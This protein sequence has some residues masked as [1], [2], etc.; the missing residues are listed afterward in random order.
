MFVLIF[1]AICYFLLGHYIGFESGYKYLLDIYK[2][3]RKVK[4]SKNPFKSEEKKYLH[5]Q[6]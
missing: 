2:G 5:Q 3:K 1:T 6:K 4:P